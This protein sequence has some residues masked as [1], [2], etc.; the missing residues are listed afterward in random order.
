[1]TV[2]MATLHNEDYIRER[3]IRIGDIVTVQRA[4]EVI[5]QVLGPVIEARTGS[6]KEFA[7]PP[8][9]PRMR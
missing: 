1:M 2:K 5:P 7:M 6:E 3:D 8:I 4:G 9:L